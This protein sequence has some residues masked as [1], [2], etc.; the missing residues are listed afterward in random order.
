MV[1]VSSGLT[2]DTS[3]DDY[4][5][6]L[7]AL[8][9]HGG[10]AQ[11]PLFVTD[12]SALYDG[13]LAA[14]SP[15]MRHNHACAACRRFVD[16][17][18][19]LATIGARGE[20]RSWL[21]HA[22]GIPARYAAAVQAMARRV[23]DARIT[24]VALTSQRVWGLP[25]NRSLRTGVTWRHI[26]I[27]PPAALVHGVSP[28]QTAA[29]AAAEVAQERVMVERAIDEFPLDVAV[30]AR[31][32][33]KGGNLYRSEKAEAIA[34][35][36]VEL[37][38]R[39]RGAKGPIADRLLWSAAATAPTGFAHLRAGMLGTLLEDVQAGVAF[40]TCGPGGRPRW[41]RRS[42]CGRKPHRPRA[43][44]PRPRRS[45]RRSPAREHWRGGS[46]DSTRS[47][48]CGSRKHRP[49]RPGAASSRTCGP[50]PPGRR[51]WPSRP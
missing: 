19:A 32:L 3:D 51:R 15:E 41:I 29:Q 33:L 10:A 17:F 16:T 30:S 49:S 31:T 38:E 46:R 24:G 22:P 23:D 4:D 9:A 48:C 42:T 26:A 35:W 28:V 11:G 36:F 14:L 6:F 40:E 47:R 1:S 18:G 20:L 13:F 21:W 45:S 7:A 25:E 37:H 39:V 12:A 2:P 8:R 43:T 34:T 50:R 44:S 27:E 5:A